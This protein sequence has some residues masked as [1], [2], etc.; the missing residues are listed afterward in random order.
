MEK[1]LVGGQA[2]IE[3]VMMRSGNRVATA[4]RKEGK[5]KI[6]KEKIRSIA[7]KYHVL[8]WPFV[9][10]FVNL[11]EFLVVGIRTLE[12]SAQE[13]AGEKEAFSKTA[14]A[15]TVVISL[16]FG[17]L[18]FVLLPYFFTYV[19]GLKEQTMPI[20]FNV[21]DGII[22]LTIL[23]I[24]VLAISLIEDVRILFQY[25]GAEHKAV[26]CYEHGKELTVKNCAKYSTKHARCGTSFLIFVIL[27]GIVFFAFIPLIMTSI[28]PSVAT[29]SRF[30]KYLVFFSARILFLPIVAGVAYEFLRITAKFE[31]NALASI[32]ILPGLLV[33]KLTTRQPN[34]RQIEVAIAALRAVV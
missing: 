8:K 24:Y 21:I 27:V 1:K 7:E 2:V 11:I 4:V 10:G 9:R 22:K 15:I 23:V 34:D 20:L 3:G 25:H 18:L 31:D 19:L 14:L 30:S 32:L 28:W 29:M 16:L 12:Y 26:A 17:I 6:K 33:Q 13:A 5:I